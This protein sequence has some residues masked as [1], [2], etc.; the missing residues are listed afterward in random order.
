MIR[1]IW[2]LC[3]GWVSTE[4][5]TVSPEQFQTYR[6]GLTRPPRLNVAYTYETEPD[7]AHLPSS[8]DWRDVTGPIPVRNQGGCGSCWAFATVG[9]VE[10]VLKNLTRESVD[11]SEQMLVSCNTAGYSCASGGWWDFE[12]LM[13]QGI[14]SESCF[15]YVAQDVG[16][17]PRC[18]SL[19]YAHVDHWRYVHRSGGI[20]SVDVLKQVIIDR[21]PVAAAVMVG[22][23]FFAY[24][25]GVFDYHMGWA[26]R[27]DLQLASVMIRNV[28]HAVVIIGWDDV[29]R[30]WLVRNSWG[31]TWGMGGHMWI[32]YGVSSIGD[33]AAYVSVQA[34]SIV[35]DSPIASPPVVLGTSSPSPSTT[36]IPIRRDESGGCPAAARLTCG[37]T[38]VT[39]TTD[40]AGVMRPSDSAVWYTFIV[41]PVA[42][43]LMMD[44]AGS[45][46]DTQLSLF[47]GG[48]IASCAFP[49]WTNDD[50]DEEDDTSRISIDLPQPGNKRW[51]PS[52]L[53]GPLMLTGH[54]Y[55]D[56][57]GPLDQSH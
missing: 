1:I 25:S 18:G 10:F 35:I 51:S 32:Q 46:I 47:T 40:T 14:V 11:I 4:Y 48:A 44:T 30:A 9:P 12:T 42:V 39:I 43:R 33:G 20:P 37:D 26:S 56:T 21:G 6:T 45:S 53:S 54:G 27:T 57:V 38:T 2:I 49:N 3:I 7:T 55:L 34:Q 16:C 52:P 15:P 24:R 28:N 17:L 19:S 31:S 8:F 29:Y 22:N 36:P 50:R 23:E 41:L 13:V 5:A